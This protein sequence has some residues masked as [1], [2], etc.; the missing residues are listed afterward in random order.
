MKTSRTWLSWLSVPLC[1]CVSLASAQ[2]APMPAE[3]ANP[4]EVELV[5]EVL[6]EQPIPSTGST[7]N[8]FLVDADKAA[9]SS[10][11]KY[12]IGLLCVDAGEALRDQLGL[13]AG[14]GL[15]VETVTEEAPAK[16]AGLRK[17][18]V[19]LNVTIA[20][21]DPKAESKPLTEVTQLVEAVQ[22]TETK[23]LRL[24]VIRRGQKQTI[25]VTPAERPQ[26][27]DN[28]VRV[29][30]LEFD[31][32]HEHVRQLLQAHQKQAE[33]QGQQSGQAGERVRANAR[34]IEQKLGGQQLGVIEQKIGEAGVANLGLRLAGPIFVH[35]PQ[36]AKLPEGMSMEFHQV[37]GQ[38]EH[39]LV[40]KG[41]QKWDVTADQLD[42]LPD[43]IRAIVAQ[44]MAARRGLGAATAIQYRKDLHS[45]PAQPGVQ[46]PTVVRYSEVNPNAQSNV[47]ESRTVQVARL[48]D[49]LSITVTRSGGEPAKITVKSKDQTHQI[50]DAELDKLPAE[51]R[52]HVEPF[53]TPR[54]ANAPST[55]KTWT[56]KVTPPAAFSASPEHAQKFAKEMQEAMRRQNEAFEKSGVFQKADSLEASRQQQNA[57]LKQ[58]QQ[59]TEKVEK[60]QQAVE[61]ST[62]K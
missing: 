50:T 47:T 16:K 19:L 25:E 60:L 27:Q 14:V 36:A 54:N 33:A 17:H 34:V 13:E 38:P 7:L 1:L 20:A 12:W 37:V 41:D 40:R 9:Q 30:V 55:L 32:E 39:I 8:A 10:S 44:Q 11:G 28:A 3:T 29:R 5:V 52:K 53:L 24:I 49:D 58:L 15:L 31:K 45:A 2:E 57:I 6:A 56:S 43:D 48:P 23:P 61:K 51:V 42:K 4:E 46:V 35:K 62:T 26:G 22:K 18:D 21:D 59:L